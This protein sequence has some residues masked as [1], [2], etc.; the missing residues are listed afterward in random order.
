MLATDPSRNAASRRVRRNR[1]GLF[2]FVMNYRANLTWT[3]PE[4]PDSQGPRVGLATALNMSNKEMD[5][6]ERQR[7]EVY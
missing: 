3:F 4:V 2:S 7:K 1:V 5:S 6:G